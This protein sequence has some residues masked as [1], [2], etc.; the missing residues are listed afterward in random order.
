MGRQ[1]D[2]TYPVAYVLHTILLV[3]MPG[4]AAKP[5]AGKGGAASKAAAKPV[6]SGK[7]EAKKTK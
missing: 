6:S 2:Y 1:L 3:P 5:A 4:A 7:S